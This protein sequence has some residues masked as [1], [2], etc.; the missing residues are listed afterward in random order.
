MELKYMVSYRLWVGIL[1][2]DQSLFGGWGGLVYIGGGGSMIF[3]MGKRGDHINLC[4][5]VREVQRG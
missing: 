2:R 1:V 5:H 4:V 3:M